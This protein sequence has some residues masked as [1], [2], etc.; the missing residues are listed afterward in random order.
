MKIKRSRA[1]LE[2]CVFS[3]LGALMFS[4]KIIMELLPNIH[5]LGMFIMA[6]T[7]AFGIKALI[8]IY[9]FV[10]LTGVYAGFA[11]WWVPYLYIW[12]VLFLMTAV[13]PK[14][15][16]KKIAVFV[17]PAVCAL[18]GFAYGTLYAPAQALLFGFDFDQT[19]AWIISGLP[20]DAIHG[21]SNLIT[22]TL[23]YPLSTLLKKLMRQAV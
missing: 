1:V 18:H 17:Y 2:L 6:Y 9:I 19:I 15:I 23:I 8:P 12:T 14:N 7:I 4:S 22:G 13:I 3:M 20:F 16:P 11:P 10:M 21:V 5:L